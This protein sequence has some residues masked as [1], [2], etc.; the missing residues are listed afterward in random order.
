MK[1][2]Y[3][4]SSEKNQD[5]LEQNNPINKKS[6]KDNYMLPLVATP[7]LVLGAGLLTSKMLKNAHQYKLA[8]PDKERLSKIARFQNISDDNILSLYIMLQEPSR[9]T[10][11]AAAGVM[12]AS[13]I[14][15]VSKNIVDGFKE[16][17]VKR[18]ES[19]IE[20]DLQEAADRSR[21]QKA[22]QANLTY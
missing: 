7:L 1:F 8:M 20:R 16:V 18:Q 21:K 19:F 14:T 12:A 15:F 9:K 11:I 13:I 5:K 22:F 10:A 2:I 4:H 6:L 17:W 3:P